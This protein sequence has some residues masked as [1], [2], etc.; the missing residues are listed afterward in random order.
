[1]A[2]GIGKQRLERILLVLPLIVPLIVRKH[3][4]DFFELAEIGRLAATWAVGWVGFDCELA[5]ET[6]RADILNR[7][8]GHHF[9]RL[10]GQSD[11][12]CRQL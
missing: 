12:E 11:L 4:Q 9:F 6:S 7:E 10:F 2:P 8:I 5:P 3:R 1:L